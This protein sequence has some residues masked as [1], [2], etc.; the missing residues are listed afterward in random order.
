MRT[1]K[2]TLPAGVFT[3]SQSQN[4]A[5]KQRRAQVGSRRCRLCSASDQIPGNDIR[6][7]AHDMVLT[8]SRVPRNCRNF[9]KPSGGASHRHVN[10]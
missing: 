7:E 10:C 5:V 8:K 1:G 2:D 6:P 3:P 4:F 9:W